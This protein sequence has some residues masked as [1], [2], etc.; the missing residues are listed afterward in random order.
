MVIRLKWKSNLNWKIVI[1]SVCLSLILIFQSTVVISKESSGAF[2][3]ETIRE[4]WQACSVAHQNMNTPQHIYH[5]LCD[6]A[7]DVVRMTYDNVTKVQQMSLEE[8]KKLAVIVRLNCNEWKF[9]G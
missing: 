4:L 5:Q 6:C 2:K 1:L 7:I 9:N 3:T 8:S